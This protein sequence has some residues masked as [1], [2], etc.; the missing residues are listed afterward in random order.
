[1]NSYLARRRYSNKRKMS[2]SERI[3]FALA[4]L[5]FV[6]YA[7]FILFFFVFAFLGALRPDG[8]SFDL[9]RYMH[10]NLFSWPENASFNSF[11]NSFSTLASINGGRDSFL[12]ITWNSVWRTTTYVILSILTSSMVCYVLVFYRSKITRFL[13]NLGILV[14]ILPLYGSAAATYRFYNNIG[15]INNPF[16]LITSIGLYGG[17]FFYMYSFYKTLSWEYAEAAFVDGASHYRV[18]FQVM[19]PMVI[20]SASALFVMSFISSWNDYESTLLYMSKYPNLAYAVFALDSAS[21]YIDNYPAYLAG[22]LI[23]LLPILILFLIFQ[24]SIMESVHLGGLK[25]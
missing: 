21:K 13:Y 3:V 18:F 2:V 17:Y 6:L 22:V 24:N 19:M 9:E 4:F 16:A 8:A 1:M 14:A 11:I 10:H 15:F 12:V 7:A 25:E 5:I 23:S 20:P